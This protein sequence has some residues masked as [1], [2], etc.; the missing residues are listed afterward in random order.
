MGIRC[1]LNLNFVV[2]E[3]VH[4]I[5]NMFTVLLQVAGSRLELSNLLVSLLPVVLK[6]PLQEYDP[7]YGMV[8]LF[9]CFKMKIL[10]C[11]TIIMAVLKLTTSANMQPHFEILLLTLRTMFK[12][13]L[14]MTQVSFLP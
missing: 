10:F 5:N 4:L 7:L 9:C 12:C 3:E 14:K 6:V 1:T 8:K 11:L 13:Q 2:L